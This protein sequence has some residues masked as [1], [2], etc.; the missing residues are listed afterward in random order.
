MSFCM[1]IEKPKDTKKTGV[2]MVFRME[3]IALFKSEGRFK[4]ILVYFS[5]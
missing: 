2:T 4:R 5:K 1:T 3:G